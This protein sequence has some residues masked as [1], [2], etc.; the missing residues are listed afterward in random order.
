[1]FPE[2]IGGYPRMR[3]PPQRTWRT[4]RPQNLPDASHISSLKMMANDQSLP[5]PSYRIPQL[6]LP[7]SQA[8]DGLLL[9]GP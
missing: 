1:M 4:A 5:R 6:P 3:V 8:D 9:D 7:L 2:L